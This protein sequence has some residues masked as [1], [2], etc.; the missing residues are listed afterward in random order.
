MSAEQPAAWPA[1][2]TWRAHDVPRME[3][4]R[5]Q[6]SGNRIKAYGQIIGAATDEHEAFSATYDLLTNDAGITRRLAV[7][8]QEEQRALGNLCRKLGAVS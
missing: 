5:V 7:L 6:L 2:L 3:S 8:T 1:I 4:V